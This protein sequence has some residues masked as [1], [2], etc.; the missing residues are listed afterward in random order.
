MCQLV[1]VDLDAIA[2]ELGTTLC[3]LLDSTHE[4][5]RQGAVVAFQCLSVKCSSEKTAKQLLSL[6]SERTAASRRAGAEQRSAFVTGGCSTTTAALLLCV[7]V[8]Q[9][10]VHPWPAAHGSLSDC[11]GVNAEL[12]SQAASD[13]VALLQNESEGQGERAGSVK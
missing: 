2:V 10:C 8:T 11:R 9:S 4:S 7:E 1:A 12:A 5:H 3:S 13:L 6:L